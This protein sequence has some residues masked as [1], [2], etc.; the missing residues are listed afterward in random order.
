M[1][2]NP[3]RYIPLDT[4]IGKKIAS[5]MHAS[6]LILNLTAELSLHTGR[7]TVIYYSS[8]PNRSYGDASAVT[9]WDISGFMR[10]LTGLDRS[11]GLDLVMQTPGGDPLAAE[12]IVEYLQAEFKG[13]VRVIVPYC[14]YSAGTLISCA[15]KSVIL[16]NHSCLGPVDPQLG[17]IPCYNI[18]KEFDQAREDI[19]A[20]PNALEYWKLRLGEYYTGIYTQCEDAVALGD[21]L[22]N[23]W[24]HKYMFAGEIGPEVDEK[25]ERIYRKLN[26]N[27]HNHG[28]H[29]TYAF[30][31]ELGLKVEQLEA[32]PEMHTIVMKLHHALEMF[33]EEQNMA[34]LLLNHFGVPAAISIQEQAPQE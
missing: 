25:I 16:G 6:E 15:A 31:K 11:M 14:A 29:F 28:R 5:G 3:L 26:S 34:K 19:I 2:N 20:N 32:D 17:H 10:V 12:G 23:I 4:K 1:P 22:L 9:E 24:L 8:F 13:D 7:N 21:E 30:C 18:L 33:M 27:N